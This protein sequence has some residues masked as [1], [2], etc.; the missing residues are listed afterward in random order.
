MGGR[1]KGGDYGVLEDGIRRRVKMLLSWGGKRGHKSALGKRCKNQTAGSM[2]EAVSLC[3]Q[4]ALPGDVVLLSPGC[5]SF[6]M[7]QNYAQR[8]DFFLSGVEN[9]KKKSL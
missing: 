9:L 5:S 7:Y 1:D 2:D 3:R 8:G 4:E 6:D